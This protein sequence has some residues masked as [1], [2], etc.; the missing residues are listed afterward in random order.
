MLITLEGIDG[1][2]KS[3]LYKGLK[4]RLAD[5][6]PVFTQ[7][8]GSPYLGDAVR[9]TIAENSD[10]LAEAALFV[11]DHAVHLATVV[12]PALQEGKLI[13]SDRYSDSRFAYQQISLKDIHPD[14]KA[15]LTAVHKG[16][17]IRPD[18]TFLLTIAPDTALSRVSERG[19][20]EHFEQKEF[21]EQVQKNYLE[22]MQ[23]DPARF[24]LIDANLPPETILDFVE[25]SIR[26][27]L[28]KK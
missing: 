25:T 3:T 22:R 12:R 19:A 6:N 14:P 10:P 27:R 8:P 18:M 1:S 4:T 16:W 24:V 11:A 9:A 23:E 13:I 15:W 17:S 21:L 26:N 5:L 2:G 28:A 7:E 20:T